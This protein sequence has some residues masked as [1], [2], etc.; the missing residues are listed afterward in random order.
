LVF[1]AIFVP[2]CIGAGLVFVERE[3]S[4][5]ASAERFAERQ[6]ALD[7]VLRE[8][9]VEAAV[10]ERARWARFAEEE[11]TGRP[12]ALLWLR[13]LAADVLIAGGDPKAL[14]P[15]L[16]LAARA[17]VTGEEMR[18]A[19]LLLDLTG[20]DAQATAREVAAR[21]A[22]S[23][24]NALE[25]TVSA[26]ILERVG[27][28]DARRWHHLAVEQAA[29]E[30]SPPIALPKLFL[31]RF[32]WL[33]GSREE[34]ERLALELGDAR[35]PARHA[36]ELGVRF[37]TAPEPVLREAAALGS[38]PKPLAAV[39]LVARALVAEAQGDHPAA[40]RALQQAFAGASS[41]FELE[42]LA[43]RAL[44]AHQPELALAAK[45]E[46]ERQ[47]NYSA[48]LELE[49]IVHAFHGELVNAEQS[50]RKLPEGSVWLTAVESVRAY[51]ELNPERITF[52]LGAEERE[53]LSRA[54]ALRGVLTGAHADYG[55]PRGSEL[56]SLF[57][58]VDW[59]LDNGDFVRA[60]RILDAWPKQEPSAA[61]LV[62]RARLA[63]LTG[64]IKQ[65][66]DHAERAVMS[67]GAPRAWIERVEALLAHGDGKGAFIAWSEAGDHLGRAREL[68][69]IH[70]LIA[71]NSWGHAKEKLARIALPAEDA[72]FVERVL[73]A[74]ALA[75]LQDPRR[76]YVREL[77]GQHP[78]N[79]ELLAASALF[80]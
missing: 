66:L 27:S 10:N 13:A 6:A 23:V 61:V 31:A 43:R 32:E 54:D 25:R 11:G 68:L 7:R 78:R 56:W 50:L 59:A 62:R 77:L 53:S 55:E 74:R 24:P 73:F 63:R 30:Q 39:P 18:F 46:L 28:S 45:S 8:L 4:E 71:A 64:D 16:E 9:S 44:D 69:E 65:A 20:P 48:A 36:L 19:R 75:V 41:S 51:E 58:G 57:V 21:S 26:L 14:E 42:W 72:T 5:R 52:K 17:G 60:K 29:V 22:V 35:A 12:A 33:A 79:A 2:F 80:R 70:V 15:A 67:G 40:R 37:R 76:P 38:V 3:R 49:A 34:A 47:K 1:L